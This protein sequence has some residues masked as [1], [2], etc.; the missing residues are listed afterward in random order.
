LPYWQQEGAWQVSE[1]NRFSP[2][3][4]RAALAAALLLLFP[5]T[6]LAAV[7]APGSASA[8]VAGGGA[9]G[10]AAGDTRP[11]RTAALNRA[12]EVRDAFAHFYILDY[13]GAL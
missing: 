13:A 10:W 9:G 3:R 5:S 11:V 7:G 1:A 4:R 12:P 2:A 6:G 8:T